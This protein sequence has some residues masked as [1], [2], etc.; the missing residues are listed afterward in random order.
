MKLL[1]PELIKWKKSH[2]FQ[3]SKVEFINLFNGQKRTKSN[4]SDHKC[5][6]SSAACWVLSIDVNRKFMEEAL[7]T[8][9]NIKRNLLSQT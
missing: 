6:Y 3:D 5:S 7:F 4:E 8:G 2:I 9:N 1:V